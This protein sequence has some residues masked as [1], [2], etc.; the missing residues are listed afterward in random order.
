[1]S[2]PKKISWT[3]K[4]SKKINCITVQNRG[5]IFIWKT[6]AILTLFLMILSVFYF[7]HLNY[8]K[9]NAL[10]DQTSDTVVNK[11]GFSIENID[12]KAFEKASI[13]INYKKNPLTLPAE[14]RNI[15]FYDKLEN[16][17]NE[18]DIVLETES[19]TNTTTQ[20]LS[21]NLKF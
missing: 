2:I 1:M 19:I 10:F 20:E 12:L 6:I 8:Q 13:L 18:T 21:L 4:L 15:F 11:S 5:E 17:K 3:K 14:L 7:L 9:T 16:F